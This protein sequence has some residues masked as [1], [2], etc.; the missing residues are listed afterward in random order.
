MVFCTNCDQKV[1]AKKS[2]SDRLRV[3]TSA[4]IVFVVLYL[5]AAWVSAGG[6][7]EESA[8]LVF[9]GFILSFII[10]IGGYLASHKIC[11]ICNDDAF[12]PLLS[13]K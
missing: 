4:A 5:M 2:S 1:R 11:P 3:F 7:A 10:L 9:I 6:Y 13:Q 12:M 8:S